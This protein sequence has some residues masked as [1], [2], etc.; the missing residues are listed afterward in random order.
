MKLINSEVPLI[1]RFRLGAV[2]GE[3]LTTTRRD[4]ITLKTRGHKPKPE[5]RYVNVKKTTFSDVTF[6][7]R[8]VKNRRTQ[9]KL[10][11]AMD[12]PYRADSH[13]GVLFSDLS[14]NCCLEIS[15][16]TAL[17]TPAARCQARPRTPR[18]PSW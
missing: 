5:G 18:S 10:E 2:H 7:L 14:S 6:V 13:S 11:F 3:F 16:V 4:S 17:K 15:T 9:P 12:S 8:P 1:S